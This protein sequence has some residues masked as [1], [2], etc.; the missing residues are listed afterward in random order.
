MDVVSPDPDSSRV[1]PTFD[2]SP[3]KIVAI[4]HPCVVLNLDKGLDL[5]G[6]QP[7]FHTV[8]LLIS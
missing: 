5:F 4:E 3:R 6:P 1:A 7:N 8:S 2:L